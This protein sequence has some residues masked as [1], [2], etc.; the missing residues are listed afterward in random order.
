MSALLEAGSAHGWPESSLHIE[1]FSTPET[2]DYVNHDFTIKLAK[3][4]RVFTVSADKSVAE[5][6][7][8][9]G[10]HV[11]MKCS[12][13]IC[14]VC[15]C[16]L[17]SGEVEHRDHVLSK[18]QQQTSMITCKSRARGRGGEIELDL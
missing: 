5:V 4:G 17:L 11:N 13:G 2:P 10:V 8:D 18:A 16:G 3:S 1:Y 7:I 15:K 9:A 6:L 12:D 14:G